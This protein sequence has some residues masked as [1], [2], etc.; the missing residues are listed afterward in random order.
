MHLIVLV[1]LAATLPPPPQVRFIERPPF[2]FQASCYLSN[3][4][5]LVHKQLAIRTPYANVHDTM[6]FRL[7]A[8]TSVL[9]QRTIYSEPKTP[10]QPNTMRDTAFKTLE[11][12]RLFANA[13]RRA[14]RLAKRSASPNAN[15]RPS[16]PNHSTTSLERSPSP[17]SCGKRSRQ[18]DDYYYDSKRRCNPESDI[19]AKTLTTTGCRLMQSCLPTTPDEGCEMRQDFFNFDLFQNMVSPVPAKIASMSPGARPDIFAP[20]PSKPLSQEVNLLSSAF[21]QGAF[22]AA[23]LRALPSA[24]SIALSSPMFPPSYPQVMAPLSF[25]RII[26][27]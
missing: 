16:V 5:H 9:C 3:L 11:T 1:M 7:R 25:G 15:V 23:G 24:D 2:A 8:R 21:L 22:W 13:I 17:F 27:A 26:L 18:E 14:R 19:E 20:S 12:P 6:Q 10:S 4:Q